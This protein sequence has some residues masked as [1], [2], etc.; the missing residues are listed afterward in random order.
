MRR[1][2]PLLEL[3]NISKNFGAIQINVSRRPLRTPTEPGTPT[4]PKT[5]STPGRSSSPSEVPLPPEE[6]G[7]EDEQAR[8]LLFRDL[9]DEGLAVQSAEGPD[10]AF[11]AAV[12]PAEE[13]EPLAMASAWEPLLLSGV[14]LLWWL[15]LAG[16][17]NSERPV[18]PRLPDPASR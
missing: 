14:A 18:Q 15:Q 8:D 3:I 4:E 16:G 9:E 1:M 10:E 17:G 13:A 7:E 11:V 2:P 6:E 5:P 12:A